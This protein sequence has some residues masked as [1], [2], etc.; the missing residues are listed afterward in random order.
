[1]KVYTCTCILK[2]AIL[3]DMTF[4]FILLRHVNSEKTNK[5]WNQSVKLLR[6]CYPH[7]KIVIIDDNSNQEFIVSD[8]EYNNVEVIQSEYPGRGELLPFVYYARHKWFDKAVIIHDSVFIHERIPFDKL[9]CAALPLWHFDYDQENLT[10]IHRI[11]N[12]LKNSADI[13]ALMFSSTNSDIGV[14]LRMRKRNITSDSIA[15]CF[16]AMCFITYDFNLMLEKRY[17]IS[18]LVNFVHNKT[19][20]CAMERIVGLLLWR[21]SNTIRSVKSL[22]GDIRNAGPPWGYTYD[23]YEQSLFKHKLVLRKVVKVWS[24]R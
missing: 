15:S 2:K 20:R 12:G 23:Q 6:T 8:F 19:D 18:N 9:S 7:R 11:V 4:G 24:G 1:M 13:Q 17:G 22:L 16:G 3:C 14:S 10:N 5:Y 21:N